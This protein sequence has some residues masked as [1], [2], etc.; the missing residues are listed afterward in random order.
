MTLSTY[1]PGLYA[2]FR[3]Q[4][5]SPRQLVPVPS[6]GLLRIERGAVRTVTWGDRGTAITLGYWG[7]GDA[8][9]HSLSGVQPYQIECKTHVEMS[10]IPA[11][12]C[13]RSLDE[14]FAHVQQTQEF[15]CML[16]TESLRDRLLQLLVLL[17]KKFGR[18]VA[19][20]L[21]I[22]LR[23]T[24]QEISESLG[25]TRITVTRLMCRLEEEGIIDRSRPQYIVLT[26]R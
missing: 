3:H 8:V 9:G 20:G 13:D 24:H 10:Y 17:G 11:N 22:D 26:S 23:L 15:F 25:I 16:R 21:L 2:S 1:T 14:I 18:Q 12:L 5:F 6:K 4:T 19:Q 7:V